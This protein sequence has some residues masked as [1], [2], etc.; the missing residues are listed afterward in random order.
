MRRNVTDLITATIVDES[1]L[2]G[3][4][5]SRKITLPLVLLALAV[6]AYAF[7]FSY[8]TL[9]R[10][11]AF[12]ARALD[13]GNLNQTIWNTAHGNWFRLTNQPGIVNR[14]SLHVEPILVPISWLYRLYPTPEM[15][16]VLQT[17]VIACGAIPA[18]LLARH[19]ARNVWLALLFALA[20]LLHPALQAANWFE[21]HPVSLAPTFLLAAVY[22]LF[23]NRSGWFAFYALL[24]A[25]CKEEVALLVFMLGLYALL[26]LRRPGLGALT[27]ALALAWALFAVLVLQ[28]MF[29]DGNIHWARYAYLG[30]SPLQMV[31]TL[32]TR[33]GV[34]FAQL[35]S[36]HILRY[37]LLL[38]LPVAF[39]AWLAPEVLLL[40]LPSLAVNLLADFPPMH[41]VDTLMYAAPI[42]PF[43]IAAGIRGTARVLRWSMRRAERKRPGVPP[44]SATGLLGA[45]ILLFLLMAQR[46]FG[47]LP[48]GGNYQRFTVSDHDR[49]AAAI[50]AQIPS[51]AKVSAQDKLNP[52]V[53]GRETV[54]IF[55]RL[56]DA[57]T[58]FLDVIGPAWPIHPNDVYTE[59]ETLLAAEFGIAAAADGYLLLS[60]ASSNKQLPAQFYQAWRMPPGHP[61]KVPIATFAN[62]MQLLDFAVGTD[63]HGEVVVDLVWR[64]SQPVEDDVRTYAAFLDRS[65]NLLHDTQFYPPVATLWY[66]TSEWEAETAVTVRTLPWTPDGRR[67]TLAV[68][69]YAG[70]DGRNAANR[71]LLQGHETDGRWLDDG[72]L[73]RLG[74]YEADGRGQW[75]RRHRSN[76]PSTGAADAIF[77]NQV[78]LHTSQLGG[79][80]F[81]AGESL[82]FTLYWEALIPPDEDYAHFVHLV[83]GS[84][85]RFAQLDWQ[86][87]DWLGPRP[88]T[89]WQAAERIADEQSLSLPPDIAPGDY[90]LVAGVYNWQTGERLRVE[91]NGANPD[92]TVTLGGIR[93]R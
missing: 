7:Y 15:L 65:G 8:L 91:G 81:L 58:V 13:M 17:V 20:Y 24:A 36:A 87:Q 31:T 89:T 43:V 50:I 27:M 68:G 84:G 1:P 32:V 67:F 28:N 41:Q 3:S 76:W 55:P 18:Y 51:D 44:H 16:L 6:L 48:G 5:S 57:D 92:N 75:L 71:L 82:P 33:P 35:Q 34:V 64:A 90:W 47:Y 85:E 52:H 30:D 26:V 60:T 21:F 10:Y 53:S 70:E 56:E 79:E 74:G 29:A 63:E 80:Q 93:I 88:M 62:G 2:S 42:V 45:L 4:G 86:P 38:T 46:D 39:T 22:C 59:V 19:Q 23:V 78:R 73:L 11:A 72:R 54:Y 49:A 83:D 77:G 66:S 40:A 37:L 12:E 61:A 9:E 25:G 69:L 14:L